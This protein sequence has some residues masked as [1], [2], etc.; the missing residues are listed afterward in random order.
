M[1]FILHFNFY[2][3]VFAYHF[4]NQHRLKIAGFVTF[5]KESDLS[6]F[7]VLFFSYFIRFILLL[8][9]FRRKK[10]RILKFPGDYPTALS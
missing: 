4:I 2:Y 7:F 9:S 6:C 3:F 8:V 1:G 5:S 10:F